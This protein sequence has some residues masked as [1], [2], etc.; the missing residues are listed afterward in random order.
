MN[1]TKFPQ[2]ET[3][4]VMNGMLAN[5]EFSVFKHGVMSTAKR[6]VLSWRGRKQSHDSS[7]G[8][9][10]AH[11]GSALG[12]VDGHELDEIAVVSSNADPCHVKYGS[13]PLSTING[14]RLVPAS[15]GAFGSTVKDRIT[16]NSDVQTQLPDHRRLQ[17]RNY[18]KYSHKFLIQCISECTKNLLKKSSLG[19]LK[20]NLVE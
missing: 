20:S 18:E 17:R 4:E 7:A 16:Q 14:P 3:S 11:G 10:V 5:S 9:L 6:L 12:S 19:S 15:M 8:R 1:P 2:G 13:G